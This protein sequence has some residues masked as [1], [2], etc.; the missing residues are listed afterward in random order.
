MND[1]KISNVKLSFRTLPAK[2]IFDGKIQKLSV[3]T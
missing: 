2:S 3:L 1:F